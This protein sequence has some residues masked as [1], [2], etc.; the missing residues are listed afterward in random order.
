M[1]SLAA[2]AEAAPAENH[3][4]VLGVLDVFIFVFFIGRW[5][6]VFH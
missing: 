2:I 1:V 4:T 6:G 5:V 3:T